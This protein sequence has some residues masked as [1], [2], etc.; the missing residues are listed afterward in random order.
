V[1]QTLVTTATILRVPFTTRFKPFHIWSGLFSWEGGEGGQYHASQEKDGFI[2]YDDPSELLCPNFRY[3]IMP[4]NNISIVHHTIKQPEEQTTKNAP[5]YTHPHGRL[6]MGNALIH[7]RGTNFLNVDS[8]RR[9]DWCNYPH[10][11]G[12]DT[13]LLLLRP[14]SRCEKSTNHKPASMSFCRP[15]LLRCEKSPR[16]LNF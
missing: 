6:F 11:N 1:I 4:L 13:T 15:D 8:E 5:K 10:L 14:A 2:I 12:V 3:P 16:N 7:D 9:W